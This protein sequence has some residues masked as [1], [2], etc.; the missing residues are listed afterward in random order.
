VKTKN[1]DKEKD[2]KRKEMKIEKD[3]IRKKNMNKND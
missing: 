2:Q 3:E 1:V